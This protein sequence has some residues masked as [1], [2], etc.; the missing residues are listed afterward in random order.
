MTDDGLRAAPLNFKEKRM[1][2]DF[3]ILHPELLD[4]AL[5]FAD[6]SAQ[7]GMPRP[8]VTDMIRYKSEQRAIYVKVGLAMIA[9]LKKGTLDGDKRA[10]A[11]RLADLTPEGLAKWA[12]D[13]FSWHLVGC[14]LD[15]RTEQSGKP[16][17]TPS[18]HRLV[19]AWFRK[20]TH[21]QQPG[22]PA[23]QLWEF[24]EHD[25]GRGDHMHVGRRDFG[26][27]RT[28]ARRDSPEVA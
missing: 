22:D 12:E 28:F 8:I 9:E 14:A 13:K 4:L 10:E 27:R 11:E 20:E 25:V 21:R 18:Q 16:V 1:E 7:N 17:Y 24:L 2:Q 19:L 3:L 23:A 15:F 6:Y 5:R 26:W